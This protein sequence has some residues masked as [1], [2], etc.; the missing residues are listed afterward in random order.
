MKPQQTKALLE[1][2]KEVNNIKGG[3]K[4]TWLKQIQKDLEEIGLTKMKQM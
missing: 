3:K 2:E 4:F 1:A